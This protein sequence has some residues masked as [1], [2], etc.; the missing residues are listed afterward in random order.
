LHFLAKLRT[1]FGVCLCLLRRLSPAAVVANAD[2]L[3]YILGKEKSKEHVG[4]SVAESIVQNSTDGII[5]ASGSGIIDV[6]NPACCEILGCSKEDLLGQHVTVIFDDGKVAEIEGQVRLLQDHQRNSDMWEGEVTC[7]TSETEVLCHVYILA[8]YRADQSIADLIV[9]IKDISEVHRQQLESQ[10]AKAESEMLLYS[11]LPRSIV[12]RLATGEKDVTFAVP[13]ASVMFIDI[14]KFSEF[15]SSLSPAQ[16]MGTLA[17]FFGAFDSR[18]VK[19]TTV[20][21]IKLIGDV[22]MCAAGL[23]DDCD[24]EV[25]ATQVVLY[26]IECLQCIEDQNTKMDIALSVRIGINTG[27]P[28]IAG[29]LGC[30]SP[31]FDIIGDAINVASRLQST[32]PPDTVQISQATHDYTVKLNLPLKKRENVMLKGKEMP[33]TTWLLSGD[34]SL[35]SGSG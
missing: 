15:S 12:Q 4:M 24:P 23:F 35:L 3:D 7:K 5:L 33:V 22:Y 16:I 14:I 10:K 20:T 2:L 32:S 26:A 31:A 13:T 29:V 21:K 18:I 11:I 9:I 30:D 6:A 19:W 28:I 17:S 25:S 8:I 1:V 34:A 27:G